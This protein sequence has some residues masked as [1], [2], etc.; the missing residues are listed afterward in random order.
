ME[1][2]R[3][4]FAEIKSAAQFFFILP[5]LRFFAKMV[6]KKFGTPFSISINFFGL[7]V[8]PNPDL[9]IPM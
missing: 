6:E 9:I 2:K 1:R 7:H 3:K 4:S 5:R 8:C